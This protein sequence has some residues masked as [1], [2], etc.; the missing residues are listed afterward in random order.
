M[1][2][3]ID[4]LPAVEEKEVSKDYI[5]LF[6]EEKPYSKLNDS[7]QLKADGEGILHMAF[8]INEK[9]IQSTM[10][11]TA[12]YKNTILIIDMEQYLNKNEFKKGDT[13]SSMQSNYDITF[14]DIYM[15]KTIDPSNTEG[16]YF[17]STPRISTNGFLIAEVVIKNNSET[18]LTQAMIPDIIFNVDGEYDGSFVQQ[19]TSKGNDFEEDV[20]IPKKSSKKLYYSVEKEP[21]IL[22]KDIVCQARID[23]KTYFFNL[24]Y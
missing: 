17:Y 16:E 22:A 24:K 3:E 21:S 9:D 23:G 2:D 15:Y 14:E 18:D 5:S 4:C 6:F 8:I 12:T 1:N 20:L 11:C 13:L 10:T 19:E 7:A